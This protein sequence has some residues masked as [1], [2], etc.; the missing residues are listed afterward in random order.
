MKNSADKMN[1]FSRT[2]FTTVLACCVTFLCWFCTSPDAVYAATLD[3]TET[4]RI[5][6]KGP[7]FA[8]IAEEV[9]PEP[10]LKQENIAYNLVSTELTEIVTDGVLTYVSASVPYELE[11]QQH[12]P[13]TMV[14]TLYDERTER[15]YKR[16]LSFLDMEELENLWEENF[17]FPITISGYDAEHFQLGN[18][19]ISKEE[20]LINYADQILESMGLSKDYY[21]IKTI[22]WNGEAYEKEGVFFRDALAEGEKW[23]R[24]VDVKYGGEIRT[25]DIVEYQYISI[26][27][28]SEE[29][30]TINMASENETEDDLNLLE[31]GTNLSERLKQFLKEH[32]KIV[33]ISS[34]LV[35]L[36][37]GVAYFWWIS[38][39]HEKNKKAR[40]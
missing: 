16:E 7:I 34:I 6:I 8:D 25:P 40:N 11:G 30:E 39:R 21:Q 38:K 36:V 14:I 10:V 4:N 5:V 19:L 18:I 17:S 24:R 28:V 33:T 13:D 20:E 32:L 37:F 31:Q 23:I 2:C 26:Y 29:N 3:A 9:K 27:E 22:V 35:L 12:P 15:E 1:G